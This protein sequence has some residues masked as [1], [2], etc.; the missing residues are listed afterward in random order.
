MCMT[1]DELSTTVHDLKELR[2]L[3]DRIAAK[4]KT[5]EDQIK[6]H[7]ADTDMFAIT[8]DGFAVTWNEVS[9]TRLDTTAL[10]HDMPD[11]AAQYMKTSITRRF[12]VN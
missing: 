8:G 1:R 4:I 10:K 6:E 12:I 11:I 3:Q 7:M 5:L 9:S 2:A